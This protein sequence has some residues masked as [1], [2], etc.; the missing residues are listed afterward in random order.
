[1]RARCADNQTAVAGNPN[2]KSNIAMYQYCDYMLTCPLLTIDL[3][4]TLNLPYK[5]TY[6]LMVFCTLFSGFMASNH[7]QPG[8]WMW[9]VYGMV[10]LP[11]CLPPSLLPPSLLPPSL[12]S[13]SLLPLP[14]SLL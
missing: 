13:P 2:S 12:L 1:M 9:F 6:A 4:W 11:P 5:L 7:P 8:R 10:S 14:P 3:L